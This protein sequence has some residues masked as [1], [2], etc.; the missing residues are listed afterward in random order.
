MSN[1]NLPVLPHALER[2][3]A[4]PIEVNSIL[5]L[6]AGAGDDSV[7]MLRKWPNAGL[8]LIEM[9]DRF[10]ADFKKLGSK[11]PR[12]RYE[13]CAAAGEDR[14]G[15]QIKSDQ[16]GGAI[17]QADSAQAANAKPVKFRR[18]DSLVRDHNL[19][20][21]YFLKFDTHG[22]ELDILAG[23]GEILANTSL[24]MME[25]Y[26]FKLRFMDFKNLTF[27]EMSLHMKELGFRCVDM[28]DPL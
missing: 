2:L 25:V 18:L 17:V 7:A 10:E 5:S 15:L 23:A 3:A 9:D 27:D 20:G 16:F 4:R 22:A 8:L 19:E 6:G 12:V 24:I 21:P 14:D 1:F 28:C 11:H 13:I 26:N